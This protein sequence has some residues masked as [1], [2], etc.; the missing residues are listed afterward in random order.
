[1]IA[2]H[3]DFKEDFVPINIDELVLE[4]KQRKLDECSFEEQA[5]TKKIQSPF[6]NQR[7]NKEFFEELKS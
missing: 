5:D 3:D 1:M 7:F 6:T 2:K 4:E